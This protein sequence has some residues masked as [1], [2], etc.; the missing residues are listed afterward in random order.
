[1]IEVV[2]IQ[3]L[4]KSWRSKRGCAG[5]EFSFFALTLIIVIIIIIIIYIFFIIIIYILISLTLG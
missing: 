3:N 2:I 1:M 5:R 4:F